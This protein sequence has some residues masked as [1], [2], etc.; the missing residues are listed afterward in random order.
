MSPPQANQLYVDEPNQFKTQP[1]FKKGDSDANLFNEQT[2]SQHAIL[3]RS[4]L[5]AEAFPAL[6][7][8]AGKDWVGAFPTDNNFDMQNKFKTK[9]TIGTLSTTYW[10][11]VRVSQ[12]KFDWYHNDAR[13]VAFLYVNTLFDEFARLGGLK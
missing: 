9:K 10:P 8:A 7:L 1:F 12:N 3:N 6:T 2:G 4:R 13:E 11:L 5:L